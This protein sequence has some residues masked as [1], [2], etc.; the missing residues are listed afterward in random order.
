VA[1][2]WPHRTADRGPFKLLDVS[3]TCD[4]G[5]RAVALAVVN[6]DRDAAQTATLQFADAVAT[7]VDAHE[8]NGAD[9]SAQNSFEEPEAVKIERRSLD[10]SGQS[11]DYT[12][13]AHSVTMLRFKMGAPE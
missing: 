1:A 12:F 2:K 7:G 5:G 4:P 6:R 3:V 13:P 11:F 8:V 9:P 10:L